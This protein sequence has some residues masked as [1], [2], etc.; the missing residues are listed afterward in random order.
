MAIATEYFEDLNAAIAGP[1]VPEYYDNAD[2]GRPGIEAP[3]S[4]WR[5]LVQQ[6]MWDPKNTAILSTFFRAKYQETSKNITANDIPGAPDANS[7][8]NWQNGQL[9]GWFLNQLNVVKAGAAKEVADYNAKVKQW[10]DYVVDPANAA[11]FATGGLAGARTAAAKTINGFIKTS[12]TNSVKGSIIGWFEHQPPN[13]TADTA[14]TSDNSVWHDKAGDAVGVHPLIKPL[15]DSTGKT[16]RGEPAYYQQLYGAKFTTGD[17]DQ[18]F[19]DVASITPAAQ[20]A[21]AAWLQ[22]PAVQQA[23]WNEAGPDMLGRQGK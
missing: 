15:T 5:A 6:A 8:S 20:R 2:P 16:W 18:P 14:W 10:V 1:P 21:F 12:G 13:Y 17:T 3:D 23:T 9:R 4:A 22:D 19:E 7:F 11:V